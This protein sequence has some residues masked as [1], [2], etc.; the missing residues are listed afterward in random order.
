M[1]RS[2][3]YRCFCI[4]H[5][6]VHVEFECPDLVIVLKNLSN[7]VIKEKDMNLRGKKKNLTKN[8]AFEK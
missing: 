4:Y 8:K 1:T 3:L 6:F 7:V 2:C 5:I